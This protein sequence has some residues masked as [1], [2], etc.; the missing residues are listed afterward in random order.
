[1]TRAH[2]A[3][4]PPT[5][6][7]AAASAYSAAAGKRRRATLSAV[8][9]ASLSCTC[10]DLAEHCPDGPFPGLSGRRGGNVSL[11]LE[12]SLAQPSQQQWLC[13]QPEPRLQP[14]LVLPLALLAG[15]ASPWQACLQAD[16]SRNLDL[17][18]IIPEER[19]FTSQLRSSF[20]GVA[21]LCRKKLDHICR[22][23]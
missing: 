7:P 20:H 17:H 3:A 10:E 14:H 19:S 5:S 6:R 15:S 18:R 12:R 4:L 22:V 8:E 1:M 23:F 2:T 11:L 13:N 9:A 21:S 16:R